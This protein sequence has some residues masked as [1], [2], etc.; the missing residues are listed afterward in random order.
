MTSCDFLYPYVQ[1]GATSPKWA[2]SYADTAYVS[3][4]SEDRRPSTGPSSMSTPQLS[5][6]SE[7]EASCSPLSA[8]DE[9]PSPRS[10]SISYPSIAGAS[11]FNVAPSVIHDWEYLDANG[12]AYAD[13]AFSA[14]EAS[15]SHADQ[16]DCLTQY[17]GYQ[18]AALP[19]YVLGLDSAMAWHLEPCGAQE[20]RP[21]LSGAILPP[22]LPSSLA[23]QSTAM[24]DPM[25]GQH[26]PPSLLI[27]QQL[28]HFSSITPVP[29]L[30][31]PRPQRAFGPSWTTAPDFNA[32][33]FLAT[34][35]KAPSPTRITP[36]SQRQAGLSGETE[37]QDAGS[38]CYE[39]DG[40][41]T[42]DEDWDDDFDEDPN[43]EEAAN[44]VNIWAISPAAVE[45]GQGI[46]LGSLTRT[47][48]SDSILYQ[49]VATPLRCPN[50]SILSW[51]SIV[52]PYFSAVTPSFP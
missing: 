29:E 1:F 46:G 45:V 25:T 2:P 39:S 24:L 20:F 17:W 16:E 52:G 31:H 49:P 41:V 11:Q 38:E 4:T 26:D 47:L 8:Y 33:E 15:V 40:D 28:S 6:S 14:A 44:Q 36:D 5:A 19:G 50:D 35:P 21:P 30:Q 34:D 3:C 27:E 37:G 43:T 12:A 18:G 13:I 32:E 9:A 7:R 42:M 51:A 48:D 10:G 22:N 23:V